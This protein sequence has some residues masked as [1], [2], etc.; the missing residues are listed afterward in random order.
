MPPAPKFPDTQRV[1]QAR[2]VT[3]APPGTPP[4]PPSCCPRCLAGRERSPTPGLPTPPSGRRHRVLLALWAGGREEAGGA[5]RRKTGAGTQRRRERKARVGKGAA[6]LAKAGR[7]GRSQQRPLH[8]S[9]LLPRA[10]GWT[11]E[12]VQGN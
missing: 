5:C 8:A 1:Y 10:L 3:K 9:L 7:K 4:P 12:S 2:T 6:E 11:R